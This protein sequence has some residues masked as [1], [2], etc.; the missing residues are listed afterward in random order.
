MNAAYLH[1][2]LQS[3]CSHTERE[4]QQ[5][6][7]FLLCTTSFMTSFI[8]M[9]EWQT[10]S[11]RFLNTK[12]FC[13]EVLFICYVNNIISFIL[14]DHNTVYLFTS[15]KS[16]KNRG[17]T[18]K[19]YSYTCLSVSQRKNNREQR[20]SGRN[21]TIYTSWKKSIS[22]WPH[23]DVHRH[24]FLSATWEWCHFLCNSR[25]EKRDFQ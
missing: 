16:M 15:N 10:Y 17:E 13:D 3:S 11:S 7:W 23:V 2:V 22:T 19:K 8:Q 18:N 21:E 25:R 14:I 9:K 24:I 5:H 6:S 4:N 12:W 1:K 20:S